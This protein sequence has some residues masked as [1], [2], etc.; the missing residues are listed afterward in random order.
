MPYIRKVVMI[1]ILAILKIYRFMEDSLFGRHQPET[2][3]TPLKFIIISKIQ[4]SKFPVFT[5]SCLETQKRYALKVFPYEDG[6]PHRAFL[7]ESRFTFFK[8]P[9]IISFKEVQKFQKTIYKRDRIYTS[10]II[11]E[12]AING[13]LT[14]YIPKLT[15]IKD[16]RLIRTIFHQLIEGIEYLHSHGVAHM[17]LK[18]DNLLLDE[19]FILKIADFDTAY[20]NHDPDILSNGTRNYRPP[21]LLDR[22]CSDPFAVDIYSAG[23]CLFILLTG[24]FPYIEDQI[25]EGHCLSELLRNES[26]LYWEVLAS[27]NISISEEAKELFLSMVK[28][29]PVERATLAE[30]KSSKW[31]SGEV[32]NKDQ[33]KSILLKR[34][35]HKLN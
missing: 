31:F 12:Y 21:E 28:S 10:Y 1:L 33:I 22:T 35:N 6:A 30:I 13:D 3:S 14:K 20:M 15:R 17:D 25:V 34:E 27:Y 11:M 24:C 23:V 9:S 4:E 19:H 7:N 26:P 16:E 32:Y 5:I 8:H 29:D 18:L 2:R